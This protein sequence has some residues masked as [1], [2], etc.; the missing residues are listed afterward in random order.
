MKGDYAYKCECGR[1]IKIDDQYEDFFVGMASLPF[2]I[3]SLF[4]TANAPV[5]PGVAILPRLFPHV[6]S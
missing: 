5:T 6:P 1:L 4:V 3:A 2:W